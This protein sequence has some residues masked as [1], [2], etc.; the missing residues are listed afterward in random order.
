MER[1]R[2]GAVAVQAQAADWAGVVAYHYAAG[3]RCSWEVGMGSAGRAAEIQDHRREGAHVGKR[4]AHLETEEVHSNIE[5]VHLEIDEV[6]HFETVADIQIL[7]EADIVV[8]AHI[9]GW[10]GTGAYLLDRN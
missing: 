6:D 7:L 9:V 1:Q 2:Q 8:V 10:E 5:K 4:G 3:A